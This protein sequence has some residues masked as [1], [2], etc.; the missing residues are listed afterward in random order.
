LLL[1]TIIPRHFPK[2]ECGS[3]LWGGT[4]SSS[5]EVAQSLQLKVPKVP[6][7]N[8]KFEVYMASLTLK[9]KMKIASEENV[10]T[11]KMTSPKFLLRAFLNKTGD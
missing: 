7:F 3:P 9:L 10:E 6:I 11:I 2:S 8:L 4:K 1:C 5:I